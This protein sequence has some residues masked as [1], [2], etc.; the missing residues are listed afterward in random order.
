MAGNALRADL[1]PRSWFEDEAALFVAR[2]LEASLL[3][4]DIQKRSRAIDSVALRIAH[5]FYDIGHVTVT[6]LLTQN[7]EEVK[8]VQELLRHANS[9][10]TLD[11]YAQAG[12]PNKRLAQSKLVR[13][14]LNKGEALA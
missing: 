6:T 1:F 8:V 12:M 3:F 2:W 11:L 7:N 5:P 13:M 10:I 14:V 4:E 9:R